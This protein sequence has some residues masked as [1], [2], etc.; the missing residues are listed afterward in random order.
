MRSL[1]SIEEPRNKTA[2]GGV[3]MVVACKTRTKIIMG[4]QVWGKDVESQRFRRTI[5]C[6]VKPLCHMDMDFAHSNSIV[7]SVNF[8]MI[9][10][11]FADLSVQ[12]DF[13]N[14]IE[15]AHPVGRVTE[16]PEE[17]TLAG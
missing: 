6:G 1:S 12:W 8:P 3:M 10:S 15:E 5:D 11:Q 4:R 16:A 13:L 14:C 9:A 7:I 17:M 2:Q